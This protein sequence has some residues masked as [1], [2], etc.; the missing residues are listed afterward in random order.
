MSAIWGVIS[1][2]GQGVICYTYSSLSL[3]SVGHFLTKRTIEQRLLI[4]V[5][6]LAPALHSAGFIKKISRDVVFPARYEWEGDE[7]TF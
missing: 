7:S 3:S 1:D 4:V 2:D 6:P 5:G